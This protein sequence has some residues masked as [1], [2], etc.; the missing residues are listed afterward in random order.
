[1][2]QSRRTFLSGM[3]VAGACLTGSPAGK[4]LP[5]IRIGDKTVSR[6]V[7]GSNPLEGGAH[8][9]KRMAQVMGNYFTLE[10]TIAFLQRCEQEGIT[11]S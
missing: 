7:V 5:A 9:T 2:R 1:M 8:S 3:A 10:R 11:S 4:T 6:L